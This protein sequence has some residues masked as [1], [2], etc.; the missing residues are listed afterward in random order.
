MFLKFRILKFLSMV[1]FSLSLK[2]T[3]WICAFVEVNAPGLIT[4]LFVDSRVK[5]L[6]EIVLVF[7]RIL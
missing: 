4:F 1:S 3:F 7:V 5:A 6:P 2:V